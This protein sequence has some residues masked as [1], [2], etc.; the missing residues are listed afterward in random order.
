MKKIYFLLSFLILSLLVSAQ[1]KGTASVSGI[2]YDTMVSPPIPLNGAIVY[3]K[4]GDYNDDVPT[5]SD[6]AYEFNDIPIGNFSTSFMV[7]VQA[8]GYFQDS[9]KLTLKDGDDKTQDFYLKS[10]TIQGRV[11]LDYVSVEYGIVDSVVLELINK[12]DTMVTKPNAEGYY[13]FNYLEADTFA[14]RSYL[15]NFDTVLVEDIV[16]SNTD[17]LDQLINM[18]IIRAGIFGSVFIPDSMEL[19]TSVE[20]FL[21][22]SIHTNPDTIT[23]NYCFQKLFPGN[24]SVKALLDGYMADTTYSNLIVEP[25]DSIIDN[26][27]N[28][29]H[30]KLI[31]DI[32]RDSVF[33]FYAEKGSTSNINTFTIQGNNLVDTL[34]IKIDSPFKIS[35]TQH[36]EYT[37]E[38][39]FI[40]ESD[41]VPQQTIYMIFQPEETNEYNSFVNISSDFAESI[42]IEC[43]GIVIEEM[44]AEIS[45][46]VETICQ[47]DSVKLKA[48]ATGGLNW[49][50][51]YLWD[52]GATDSLIYVSPIA[53]STFG[54]L[55]EDSLGNSVYTDKVVYVYKNP[56][57]IN[58]PIN[59]TVCEGGTSTFLLKVN[60]EDNI[61]YQW[62][63]GDN[64]IIDNDIFSGSQT[65][66]LII[67]KVDLDLNDAYFSCRFSS[68]DSNYFSED[69]FLIVNELPDDTIIA[70]GG[71][72]PIVLISPDSGL[73]YQWYR[74]GILLDGETD[75]FFHLPGKFPK[76]GT[77]YV[78]ITDDYT[79]CQA[80]SQSIEVVDPENKLVLY[81]NPVVNEL[82]IDASMFDLDS[83]LTIIITDLAG[84]NVFSTHM[85]NYNK[86][87]KLPISSLDDGIYVVKMIH[88]KS[89]QTYSSKIVKTSKNI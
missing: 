9:V 88:T 50:Y 73:V 31:T 7:T 61:T 21:N 17:T 39:N 52:N 69:V 63:C 74:N 16:I 72:P 37:Q 87:I 35:L 34:K 46:D 36:G 41:V 67:N 13:L 2:V 82:N 81:P 3:I 43:N 85:I 18:H 40:P 58:K 15:S 22:D 53:D 78:E 59:D 33:E 56:A 42:S 19:V 55:V 14:I 25:G 76:Q 48:M 32:P 70:K 83:E 79:G 86:H 6:G 77:Y 30:P 60:I 57:I 84:R 8:Q 66:K 23:G 65:N 80:I 62:F 24:Y 47:G 44:Q 28:L 49:T 54:V 89:Q 1:T 20:V 68:C 71:N 27:F 75:Q 29:L 12:K 38:I 26:N 51:S 11:E 10:G 4:G 45:S 5:G 64:E